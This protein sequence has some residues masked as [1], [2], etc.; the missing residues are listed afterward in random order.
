[1]RPARGPGSGARPLPPCRES[2]SACP[3]RSMGLRVVELARRWTRPAPR[4]KRAS[5]GRDVV[6]AGDQDHRPGPLRRGDRAGQP[7]AVGEGG[8]RSADA[9]A[10]SRSPSAS[11]ASTRRGAQRQTHPG[12]TSYAA[13]RGCA[14]SGRPA[15]SRTE[16][17][18][19]VA[20][21]DQRRLV[22]ASARARRS[23]RLPRRAA[24]RSP[25]SSST[26]ARIHSAHCTD[27]S[28]R[29]QP[30]ASS[31]RSADLGRLPGPPEQP[32][33]EYLGDQQRHG[34]RAVAGAAGRHP[35]PACSRSARP[36]GARRRRAPTA[37]DHQLGAGGELVVCRVPYDG[38]MR[39][40]TPTR[41]RRRARRTGARARPSRGHGPDQ[42]SPRRA[43]SAHVGQPVVVAT[44]V[45]REGQCR[46]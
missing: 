6:P 3:A 27:W 16:P 25:R 33:S 4:T 15:A 21:R 46:H 9:A 20:D 7:G 19:G 29:R 43:P 18:D 5:R 11:R 13:S 23:P 34:G 32:Q 41:P 14:S 8:A 35:T 26:Q 1:M 30:A 42:P 17:E 36:R 44:L 31:A 12:S 37:A 39:Q 10:P 28:F 22:E 38:H 45:G 2:A 24:S 40:P